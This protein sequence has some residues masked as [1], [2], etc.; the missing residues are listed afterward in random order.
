M[1]RMLTTLGRELRAHAPFTA[2]GT[3]SGLAIVLV[4]VLAKAQPA[5]ST[6]LFWMLHPVHVLFS[7]L[8]TTA[9]YRLHGG[10]GV[11]RSSTPPTT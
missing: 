2:L 1:R 8:V 3:L 10:R 11:W 5:F 9:T 6:G 4:L 7:A